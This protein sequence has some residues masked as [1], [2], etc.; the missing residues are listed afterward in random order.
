MRSPGDPNIV[1]VLV[2]E[3]DIDKGSVIR[4]QYPA[5]V[6]AAEDALAELMLPEGAHNHEVNAG[7]R[8]A[9]LAVATCGAQQ[10]GWVP[11]ASAVFSGCMLR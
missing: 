4:A 3:F 11:C 10:G 9:G 1:A 5:P 7:A 8:G 2:A 6:D